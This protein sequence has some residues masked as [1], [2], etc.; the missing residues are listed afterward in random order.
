MTFLKIMKKTMKIVQMI[1]IFVSVSAILVAL[2]LQLPMFGKLPLGGRLARIERSPNFRDGRFHNQSETPLMTGNPASTVLKF[3]WRSRRFLSD[4]GRRPKNKLPTIKTDLKN[5]GPQEDVLVWFGHSS[6]LIHLGGRNILVDPLFSRVSS[7]ILFFPKAFSGTEIYQQEDMP[8]IDYL[9]ITHDHWDHLDYE[10]LLKLAPKIR[11][12]ICGLGV[13]AHLEHWGFRRWQIIE[14]D[15]NENIS[16]ETGLVVHCLSARHFSGRGILRNRSLWASFLL[17]TEDFSLYIGGDGGYGP[18]FADIGAKFG[19]IDLVILDSGQHDK[20]WKHVHMAT[21]EV[22]R[23]ARDLR[24]KMLLPVHI[25]K[26]S[27]ANHGWKEPLVELSSLI[28]GENFP[29]LTPII[30]EKV[31]LRSRRQIFRRWWENCE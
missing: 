3:L 25:C 15:W 16:P 21:D 2:Y 28:N 10:A 26:I 29:L 17:K 5:L 20:N 13:G 19:P 6:Y 8:E 4:S 14:M 1:F 18:H 31:N 11:K 9:I 7:P 12:I 30:G 22:V 24:A 27:L 23:A